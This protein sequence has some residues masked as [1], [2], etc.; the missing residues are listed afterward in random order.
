MILIVI[1]SVLFGFYSH[2]NLNVVLKSNNT[3]CDRYFVMINFIHKNTE[4]VHA[5]YEEQKKG[6]AYNPSTRTSTDLQTSR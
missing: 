3:Q 5:N 4:F 2:L 1:I 6:G